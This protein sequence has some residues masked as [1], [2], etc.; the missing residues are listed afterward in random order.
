[1]E[2]CDDGTP[3]SSAICSNGEVIYTYVFS[4]DA[5]KNITG[6]TITKNTGTVKTVELVYDGS[7]AI[8]SMKS[9][10]TSNGTFNYAEYYTTNSDGDITRADIDNDNDGIVDDYSL[11][12]YFTAGK[13]YHYELNEDYIS[14]PAIDYAADYSYD[15]DSNVTDVIIDEDGDGTKDEYRSY[16]YDEN[17][18]LAQIDIAGSFGG[19]PAGYMY[20]EYEEGAEK[21]TYLGYI[22]MSIGL[23]I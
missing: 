13:P 7:N 23:F 21:G 16:S 1:M 4:R 10:Y 2:N 3:K 5:A 8:V 9:D 12:T 19:T 20:M 18:K 14:V 6:I 15:A 22:L 17:G 11:F